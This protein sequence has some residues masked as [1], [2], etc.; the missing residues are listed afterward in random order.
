MARLIL[1]HSSQVLK[2]YPFAKSS[3]T[4]GRNMDNTI[5]LDDPSVSGYHA[6][7]DKRGVDYI[8]TDLQSTNGTFINDVSIVSHVLSHGDRIMIGEHAILFVGTELSKAYEEQKNIDLNK[9]TIRGVPQK[10]RTPSKQKTI[11]R[12]E[13][14]A[15]E[16]KHSR[17]FGRLTPILLSIFI[18]TAGGWYIL[19]YE[20]IFL[21]SLFSAAIKTKGS[22]AE[23]SSSNRSLLKSR[24]NK[25]ESIPLETKVPQRSVSQLSQKSSETPLPENNLLIPISTEH[26]EPT[27]NENRDKS[28]GFEQ[29]LSNKMDEPKY[30]LEGIVWASVSKDSF[31]VINGRIVKEGRSF[32]G[33]TI[34]EI[35]QRYVIIQDSKD[36]SKIKLTLR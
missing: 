14:P 31:A 30:I 27:E 2:D 8:L 23:N 10:R 12:S 20:P 16:V 36:N 21:K 26:Q 28:D 1:E 35:G 4:I 5:V 15:R 19:N 6:R 34:V 25:A 17:L 18:L 24:S 3:L 33:I 11:E 9:T 22:N 29:S 32:K 13:I 7:I